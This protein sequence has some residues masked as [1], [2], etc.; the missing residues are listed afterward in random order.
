[1]MAKKTKIMVAEM[2]LI[3]AEHDYLEQLRAAGVEYD[4]TMPPDG[5]L[6]F[7]WEQVGRIRRARQYLHRG[8]KT[9]DDQRR[10]GQAA[11]RAREALRKRTGWK[12][13]ARAVF[14]ANEAAPNREIARLIYRAVDKRVELS[15][16]AKLVAQFRKETG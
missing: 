13:K 6:R 14:N 11:A 2:P 7:A 5:E 8:K 10:A 12:E 9:L 1:M 16:I 15:T 4:E 3:G